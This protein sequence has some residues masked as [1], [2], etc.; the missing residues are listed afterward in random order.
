MARTI[1][2]GS[3]VYYAE[4]ALEWCQDYFGLCDRKRTELRFVVSERKRKMGNSLIYGNYCFW[5]NTIT[6]YLPNTVT[7][8]D[9]VSTMIHEYTHYLQSRT[10]YRGYEKTHYYSQNPLEKEARRNE[11]KYS[12]MCIRHIKKNM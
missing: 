1:D 12:K 10:R 4:K 11:D 8:H 2:I 3:K 7:I 6:L 9:I 5:R